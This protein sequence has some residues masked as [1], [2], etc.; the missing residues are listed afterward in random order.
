MESKIS[1]QVWGYNN[2]MEIERKKKLEKVLKKNISY[3]NHYLQL[4]DPKICEL[5]AKADLVMIL[6]SVIMIVQDSGT[7]CSN[8]SVYITLTQEKKLISLNPPKH[9]GYK[10]FQPDVSRLQA[11]IGTH[12]KAYLYS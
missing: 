9:D 2:P 3:I 11:S 10:S 12:R 4:K 1:R 8:L 7:E 5:L 6:L